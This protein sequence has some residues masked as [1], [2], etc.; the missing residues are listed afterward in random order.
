V[1]TL[2]VLLEDGFVLDQCRRMGKYFLKRLEGLKREFHSLVADVRG[3]GLM[4]GLELVR[5]CAPIV[6]MC[7][8]R[9]VLVN[10]TAGN[11]LRFLPP[12]IVT[13]NE[14]DHLIDILEQVFDRL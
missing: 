2:D 10:C 3:M 13:E 7:M 6:K 5:D 11:V 8:D 1:A 14:I 12:L 4:I 9:G